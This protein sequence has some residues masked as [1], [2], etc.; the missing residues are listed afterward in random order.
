MF[1][2]LYMQMPFFRWKVSNHEKSSAYYKSL[3]LEDVKDQ[4][5][6]QTLE[7]DQT[8]VETVEKDQKGVGVVEIENVVSEACGLAKHAINLDEFPSP[9][10]NMVWKKADD[11]S[12]VEKVEVE[13]VDD[14][15]ETEN[16]VGEACGS[17]KHA[18]NLD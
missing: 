8:C 5:S 1:C 9:C 7:N 4:T 6:V 10:V 2:A 11:K 3:M 16:V 18:I 12:I 17:T 14:K 15:E 13:K